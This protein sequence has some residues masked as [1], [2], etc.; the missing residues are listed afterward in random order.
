M[1]EFKD[2][3]REY[4]KTEVGDYYHNNPES[5]IDHGDHGDSLSELAKKFYDWGVEDGQSAATSK[6]GCYIIDSVVT[7]YKVFNTNIAPVVYMIK[8]EP[9]EIKQCFQYQEAREFYAKP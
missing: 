1:L 9:L 6:S 2:R 3:A 4:N 7:A 8:Y 5:A